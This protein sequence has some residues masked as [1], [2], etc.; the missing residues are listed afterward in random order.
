VKWIPDRSG[1]FPKRLFFES[2]AELDHECERLVEFVHFRQ[3]GKKFVPPLDDDTLQVLIEHSADVDLFASLERGVEGE[4]EFRPNARPLIR[5]SEEIANDPS[6]RNR[7]RTGMAHEWFHAAYHRPVWEI[8]WARQRR[9][10]T[11]APVVAKCS[12]ETMIAAPDQNWL[13][14]QAGYASCAILMPRTWLD[15]SV[16]ELLV[17][18]TDDQV[19]AVINGVAAEYDVSYEAARWR[20]RQLGIIRQLKGATA[21]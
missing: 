12:R 19:N 14:F 11:S 5:M 4:T 18:D 6:R 20:L 17:S 7:L 2:I 3:R 16:A 13:E 9:T 15:R 1:A 10:G 21:G 8:L